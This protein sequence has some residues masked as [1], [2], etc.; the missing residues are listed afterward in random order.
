MSKVTDEV[1]KDFYKETYLIKMFPMAH[2]FV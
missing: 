1:C 2:H